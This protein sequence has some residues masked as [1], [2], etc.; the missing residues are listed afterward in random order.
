[1]TIWPARIVTDGTRPMTLS[2]VDTMPWA[3]VWSIGTSRTSRSVGLDELARRDRLQRDDDRHPLQ[4]GLAGL[5]LGR[6]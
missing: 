1:M 6:C 5:L 4:P 3:F 2:G